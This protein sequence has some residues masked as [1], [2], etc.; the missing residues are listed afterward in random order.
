MAARPDDGPT[1]RRSR[2]ACEA[3]RR[4]SRSS[5]TATATAAGDPRPRLVRPSTS[6]SAGGPTTTSRSPGTREVSRVHA[7]ARARRARVGRRRRRAVAQRHVRQRRARRRPPARC[8]TATGSC[9][10]ET[11]LLF[12]A[13]ADAESALDGRDRRRARPDPGDARPA[14]GARRAVPAAGGLGLRRARDQPRD[15]RGDA[16]VSVDAVKAHLRVLFDRFGVDGLPQNQKRARLAAMA[17]V[18]KLVNER[19]F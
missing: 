19:D 11:A 13:P 18:D 14:P 8:A 7:A 10:G 2:S 4:G 15:R 5:S 6:R 9:V 3:E 16:P 17:L 12:R 1:P